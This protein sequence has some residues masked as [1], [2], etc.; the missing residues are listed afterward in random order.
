MF[1]K[2]SKP[3]TKDKKPEKPKGKP[4]SKKDMGKIAGGDGNEGGWNSRKTPANRGFLYSPR[5]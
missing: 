2:Q 3:S 5:L 4:V 1:M